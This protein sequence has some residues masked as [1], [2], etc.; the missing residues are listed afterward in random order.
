LEIRLRSR[1]SPLALVG[2]VL[3]RYLFSALWCFSVVDSLCGFRRLDPGAKPF[4]RWKSRPSIL[5]RAMKEAR[6]NI[7]K[8]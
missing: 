8:K 1:L 2:A 6:K 3:C 7:L 5:D 4:F